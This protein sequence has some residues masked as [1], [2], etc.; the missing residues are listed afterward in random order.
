MKKV[1][2]CLG[3]MALM[4]LAFTSCKKVEQQSTFKATMPQLVIQDIQDDEDR[5]YIDVVGNNAV[6]KF[7]KNDRVM[8]F[9]ISEDSAAM[10][11]CAVYK[12]QATGQVVDFLNAGNGTV[13]VA[14]DGGYY[15]YYPSSVIPDPEDPESFIPDRI[16]TELEQGENKSKFL[17]SPVQ[18]YRPQYVAKRDLY[19][20]AK[21][22]ALNLADAHFQFKFICGVLQLHAYETP[23]PTNGQTR[24]VTKI[25]VVD[26]NMALSGWVEAIIPAIDPDAMMTLFNNFDLTNPSYVAALNQWRSDAGINITEAGHSITLDIPEGVQ[27]GSS[28]NNPAIFNIVLRP[29]AL[30]NGC[31]IILTFADGSTKDCNVT[32]DWK[33]CPNSI[34]PKYFNVDKY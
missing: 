19:L 9:N 2:R 32:K 6:V 26:N 30:M 4:A 29:L 34:H 17:V 23:N 20:A 25:E 10:S 22:D 31:H 33:I 18:Q 27:L 1:I 28:K 21:S 14:L 16:E 3:M 24:T 13:G 8:I 12:A 15:A 11:H 7:E 5:A